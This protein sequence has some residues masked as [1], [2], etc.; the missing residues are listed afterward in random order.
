MAFAAA[1]IGA[2][3]CFPEESDTVSLI[4]PTTGFADNYSKLL[5]ICIAVLVTGFSAFWQ[6]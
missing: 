5:I 1:T 2:A 4:V 6:L 3:L